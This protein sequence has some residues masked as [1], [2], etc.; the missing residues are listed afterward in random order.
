MLGAELA[1]LKAELLV[2]REE[3]AS[4]NDKYLRKLADEVNFRKRMVRDKEEARKF[5][6]V[7]FLRDMVPALD[8]FDRAMSS[9]DASSTGGELIQGV[10][11]IRRQIAQMLE[12][13]YGLKKMESLGSPF[14][15]NRHEAVAMETGASDEPIV[16]EEYLPG[17]VVGE[18]VVRTAK[19]KVRMPAPA[20]VSESPAVAAGEGPDASTAGD[21]AR[22]DAGD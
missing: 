1:S 14:D 9:V 2:V 19:V 8:D 11:L 17:Y 16:S 22:P 20:G 18:T 12:N 21:E 6:V 10:A 5:A 15:P 13:K 7:G 3:M 4:L